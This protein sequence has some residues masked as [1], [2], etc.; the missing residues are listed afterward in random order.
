VR[1]TTVTISVNVIMGMATLIMA[2]SQ[3][4]PCRLQ[5]NKKNAA[6]KLNSWFGQRRCLVHA[7]TRGRQGSCRSSQQS[8]L[9]GC[10]GNCCSVAQGIAS[11]AKIAVYGT[12]ELRGDNEL[13]Q[14]EANKSFRFTSLQNQ[15]GLSNNFLS[16]NL[17]NHAR[18]SVSAREAKHMQRKVTRQVNVKW[19]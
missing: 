13:L 12:R 19:R 16:L 15:L 10:S 3:L 5:S 6:E 2:M 8:A 1:T 7:T 14:D 4:R 17:M 18:L 11:T 9:L